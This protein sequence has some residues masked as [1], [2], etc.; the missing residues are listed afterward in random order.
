MNRKGGIFVVICFFVV[1]AVSRVWFVRP[2]AGSEFIAG[3][4]TFS[5]RAIG[6]LG[7]GGEKII[8]AQVS[9]FYC[10]N[11][12]DLETKIREL[13]VAGVNTL[14]VRVFQNE[15]DRPYQ[16]ATARYPSGVYFQ[17]RH[18]P[19]VGDVLGVVVRL[20]HRYGLKV[21]AWMT[22]RYANYGFESSMGLR[23]FF[24]DFEKGI[25]APGKGFNLFRQ[26]VVTRLEGLY[27]DLAQ[28]PIDGILFQDDLI[29]KHN[30]GFSDEARQL[31]F[32]DHGYDPHPSLLYGETSTGD[33]G[34]IVVSNYTDRFWIWARWKNRNVLA[35][36]QKLMNAARTIR[37][38]LRFAIN[39]FYESILEPENAMAWY[40][41]SLAAARDLSFDYFS[42]MAYHRQM[43]EELNLTTIEETE[44]Q[45]AHLTEK[46]VDMVGDPSRVLMKVQAVDWRDSR[47]LPVEETERFLRIVGAKP[48]MHVAVVPY[49]PDLPMGRMIRS[50]KRP[51]AYAKWALE[52]SGM[53]AIHGPHPSF[54]PR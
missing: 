33:G 30:E 16:F 8:A 31:F 1:M 29:L 17:T 23:G 11:L 45:F 25:M 32:K 49:Q 12:R 40:S 43:Q 15:G 54:S 37:P 50:L 10:Q 4:A 2:V 38:D 39:I 7:S 3:K 14:I 18:A 28:Y 52:D 19:V 44:D 34:R 46:A 47:L 27:G 6:S 5:G 42:I 48:E 24:Y 20:A 26:D 35:L 21:F 41:Q 36:A 22:T 9:L 53:R 51:R 13:A